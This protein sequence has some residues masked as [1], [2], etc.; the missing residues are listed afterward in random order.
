MTVLTRLTLDPAHP[1]AVADARDV[2]RAHQTVQAAAA[3]HPGERVLWARP[4]PRTLYIQAPAPVA[5]AMLPPGYAAAARHADV[6]RVLSRIGDGTPVA[7]RVVANPTAVQARPKGP[8]GRRAGPQ[9]RRPVPPADRD[10]WA[11]RWLAAFTD[12]ET[13]SGTD[14]GMRHGTQTGTGRKISVF[15]YGVA[16]TGVITDSG[17]MARRVLAGWGHARAFGCGLLTVA[18]LADAHRCPACAT[19]GFVDFCP[20]C[21]L[22]AGPD[23]VVEWTTAARGFWDP[24]VYAE[25]VARRGFRTESAARNH[26]EQRERTAGADVWHCVL[27][28]RWHRGDADADRVGF[29]AA[30]AAA[31]RL[32]IADMRRVG[33]D[34]LRAHEENRSREPV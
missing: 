27:C 24:R 3:G 29:G 25:C 31:Y 26:S 8:D 15:W 22:A 17:E 30:V 19:I 9:R 11:R 10:G 21:G 12:V 16:G 32:T 18:P 6:E 1:A 4:D 5:P 23:G 7:L 13:L 2:Y 14:L 33:W 28:D 20:R 34:E